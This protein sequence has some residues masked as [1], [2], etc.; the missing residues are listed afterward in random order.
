VIEDEDSGKIILTKRQNQKDIWYNLYEFPLIES[1]HE[2]DAE[3]LLANGGLKKWLG[4]REFS[5]KSE[6]VHKKHQLS[7]QTLHAYFWRIRTNVQFLKANNDDAV[8]NYADS[9]DE[10][11]LPRLISAFAEENLNN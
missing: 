3:K 10:Y 7:H 9:L 11:P 5:L 1:E 6:P 8:I 2:L 4:Q